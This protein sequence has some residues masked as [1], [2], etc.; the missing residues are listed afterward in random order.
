MFQY[1]FKMKLGKLN[2]SILFLGDK[3]KVLLGKIILPTLYLEI[4]TFNGMN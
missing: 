4:F 3:H 2:I 1:Y